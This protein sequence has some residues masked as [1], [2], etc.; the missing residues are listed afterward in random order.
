MIKIA[1]VG[2]IASGKSQV[3]KI[4]IE[5]GLK[6]I[7]S[8]RINHEILENDIDTISK[9]KLAF[10]EIDV[11]E[12]EKISR[13]KLGKIVFS[14]SLQKQKLEAIL[15][16]KIFEN[17][18][19]FFDENVSEKMVFVSVPLLFETKQEKIF[20][21]IIFVSAD[22]K[23]RLKRLIE[24]NNYTEE[25]AI[26]RINSQSNEQEKIKKSDFVIYNNSDLEAL[27]VQIDSI[28]NS[29]K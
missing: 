25:Y 27:K 23:I 4:L 8:D 28:L 6:V 7:D 1:I 24:R 5:K 10:N 21:K 15:H 19:K 9:I 18:Q 17:I 12:D 11:L 2:N 29:L 16:S 13:E 26:R 22:E 3:E 20:D 14:D